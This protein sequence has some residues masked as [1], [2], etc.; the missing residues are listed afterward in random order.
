MPVS[1]QESAMSGGRI[2]TY[3]QRSMGDLISII[4]TSST[5]SGGRH[6][7]LLHQR[8]TSSLKL[9]FFQRRCKSRQHQHLYEMFMVM[10][11]HYTSYDMVVRPTVLF[12]DPPVEDPLQEF[13]TYHFYQ[14][15]G[16]WPEQLTEVVNNLVLIPDRIICEKTR[17]SSTKYLAIFLML[18]RWNK[19]DTWDDVARVM[20][21]GRVWCLHIYRKIFKLLA[22][23]YRRCVQVIDYRRII[24][25]LA[26]WSDEVVW[27][28]G[29][30]RDVL[31]FTDG[32]P[33]KMAR[34]GRGE[35]AQALIRAVG[36]DEVNLVQQAY[37][38]GHYGFCGGKVQHVLQADGMCYS[39]VCPLRRHDA[40]VLQSSSMITMLSVLYINNDPE[41]PVKT[42]TDKA[43]GRLRHF[44]PLLT[45]LE[46]RLMNAGDRA[47]AE[48][49]DRKNK[50]P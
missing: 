43:Y 31:F 15:C 24:P 2:S 49:E 48:E 12:P 28:S 17:C 13:S 1:E 44:R 11:H 3:M 5:R 29:C 21:R 33:W 42:C 18:R 14:L 23:H 9:S 50:G 47:D 16:F 38:N 30:S 8:I 25:L 32:K 36:G 20:R 46:L 37:Y 34:P 19:A 7:E 35:A 45:D 26:D 40:M 6:Q 22:S 27:H 4:L 41:R 10:Y 39:F